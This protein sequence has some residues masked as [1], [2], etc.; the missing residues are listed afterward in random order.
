MIPEI[1]GASKTL[2]L[3]QKV[4]KMKADGVDIVSFTA[5]VPDFPT[6]EVI[7]EKAFLAIK[8]G[9]TGYVASQGKLDLREV[10]ANDYSTRLSSSWVKPENV[11]VTLGSKQGISLLFST[12]LNKGDEV[13]CPSPYWVSYPS[14]VKACGG[15]L[16]V[17]K[18]DDASNFFPTVDQLE[19]VKTE[20]TKVLIF[21]SPNNPSGKMIDQQHLL[22]VTN[23][24]IKN[25]V[26]FIYDEIYERLSLTKK[27][28][29]V[30]SLISEQQS[31]YII[32]VNA[33]SKSMAMTGWRLGY[34]VTHKLNIKS[35]AA[36]QS[37]FVTCAPG[38]VQQAAMVGIQ[39]AD[40][41]LPEIVSTFTK[42]RNY[43]L[44]LLEEIPEVSP[45]IPE[46]AFY[47]LL[48]VSNILEKKSLV[49]DKKFAEKLLEEQKLSVV[50][51]SGFGCPGFVRLAYTVD[52]PEIKKG[53]ER[54]KAFVAS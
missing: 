19:E 14:L 42:R 34:V 1:V 22:D 47:V 30:L 13:I 6:P 37:Q 41:F 17:I 10:I 45:V 21:S 15:V 43:I 39:S 7:C 29:C 48:D 35:L 40:T 33:C 36:M 51:G 31:E 25:K 46:G 23:W 52:L 11:L 50:P 4:N 3:L 24:C 2:A 20:K 38:F 28:V 44:K 5:G 16:K 26:Y 32:S 18:A 53:I 49:D 12:L 9:D 54:L 27:H 8:E